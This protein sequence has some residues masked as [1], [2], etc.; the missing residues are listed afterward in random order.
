MERLTAAVLSAVIVVSGCAKDDETAPIPPQSGAFEALTYNVA[1]LPEGLSGS[2]PEA[3]MPL[4]SPLLNAF[5][6][7]LVQEDFSYHEALIS[8]LRHPHQST[9]KEDFERFVADGLNRFAEFP[10]TDFARVQWDACFGD[11]TGGASDCLAEK[12]FSFGRTV[13]G[14]RVTL[15]VYNLHAEAGGGDEDIAAREIGI[16]QLIADVLMRSDGHAVLIGGDTNL[17]RDDPEDLVLIERIEVELGVEDLCE[18]LSCGDDHID[19]FFFRSSD[20]VEVTPTAWRVADEFVDADGM[21][22]SDHNAIHATI[23][24]QT[25]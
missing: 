17:H 2:S 7:V 12:G 9:P 20:L 14:D 6:L 13:L 16:D 11:A 3:N 8:E 22:L 21:D 19:R 15:D 25:R 23:S 18:H 5:D 24:W 1:G 4:I 10:W